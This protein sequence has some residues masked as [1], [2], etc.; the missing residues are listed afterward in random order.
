MKRNN[1]LLKTSFNAFLMVIG[2]LTFLYFA[3]F[4]E[5]KKRFIKETLVEISDKDFLTEIGLKMMHTKG[6]V[7][8]KK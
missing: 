3:F 7:L 4:N 1:E 5:L 6:S 8:Y 2:F